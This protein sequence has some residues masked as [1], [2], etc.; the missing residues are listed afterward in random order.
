MKHGN[1]LS[2]TL[3]MPSGSGDIEI[4]LLRRYKKQAE[5]FNGSSTIIM[6]HGATF[7][8]G[9]LYDT[10]LEGASFMDVMAE[11]GFDVYAVDVR[12][13]GNSTRPPS[14]EKQFCQ[15]EPAVRT[16]IAVEDFSAAVNYV[17]NK[18]SLSRVNIIGMSW[19]GTVAASFT[20]RNGEKVHR[21]GLIAPQWL[22]NRPVPID[23]GGDLGAWRR[24]DINA[25]HERWLSSAPEDKRADLIPAGGFDAWRKKTLSYEPDRSFRE[26]GAIKASNGAIQ[27]IREYWTA[28]R[29]YYNPSDIKAP[30]LLIHGEWDSDVPVELMQTWFLS[31]R[32]SSQKRWLEIGEATHMMVLEKNRHQ[33]FNALIEFL[34]EPGC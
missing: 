13:Y 28:D 15:T 3:Q 33:V 27:D 26:Q 21:L 18:N 12:G 7:S 16:D 17:M 4:S 24:V 2:E 11:A 23:S 8:S 1:L 31:A 30:L 9:S 20:I 25:M 34:K 5:P 6:M 19:G 32:G 10:E 22:S 14:M 29:P